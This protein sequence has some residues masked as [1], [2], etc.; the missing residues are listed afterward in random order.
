MIL[1]YKITNSVEPMLA[2]IKI[3]RYLVVSQSGYLIS[4]WVRILLDPYLSDFQS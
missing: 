1:A 3:T 4:E 2:K